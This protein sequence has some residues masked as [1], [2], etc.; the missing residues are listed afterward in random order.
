MGQSTYTTQPALGYEGTLDETVP[1]TELTMKNAEDT[2]SIAFGRA[3]V[4]KS[5]GT[6]DFD[7]V[8]PAAETDRVAGIVL[9]TNTYDQAWTDVNGTVHGQLKSDGLIPGTFMRV[10]RSGRMLVKAATAVTPGDRLWVRAVSGGGA[11]Y[12]GALED[13]DDGTDTIDCTGQAQWVSS[14]SA[15]ELAWLEFNFAA[16]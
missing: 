8:L 11:E 13:A 1:H 6:S 12:L 9:K 4:F 15:G 16:N 5:G 14:A 3:V 2:A 7:A 10:I